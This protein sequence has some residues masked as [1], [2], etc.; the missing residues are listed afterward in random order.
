MA[1]TTYSETSLAF[2]FADWKGAA[3]YFDDVLCPSAPDEEVLNDQELEYEVVDAINT[4]FPKLRWMHRVPSIDRRTGREEII[5]PKVHGE[6]IQAFFREAV[7]WKN[8]SEGSPTSVSLWGTPLVPTEEHQQTDVALILANLRLVD[9][10]QIG[11]RQILEIRRDKVATSQLRMLR[12]IVY[13]DYSGKPSTYIHDDIESRIED[14]R[15]VTKVW[16][17]PLKKGILEIAMTGE[18]LTAVGAVVS[19]ACFGAPIAAA[20]AA[21]GAIAIGRAALSFAAR[22]R[23]VQLE[24]MRNPMAYLV[25]LESAARA[26]P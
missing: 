10:S 13:K 8:N 14:Y 20:V 22:K 16:D 25:R 1:E 5:D 17:L 2:A 4:R 15:R 23:E 18:A 26:T 7:R 6:W 21:G 12:R 11:W 3:L 9:A 19:L 24:E